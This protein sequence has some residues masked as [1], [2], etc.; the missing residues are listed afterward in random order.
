M[1]SGYLRHHGK[2]RRART[3]AR[4][5]QNSWR[6]RKWPPPDELH[7]FATEHQ[8]HPSHTAAAPSIQGNSI[9]ITSPHAVSCISH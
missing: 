6:T 5:H 2:A 4:F 1:S 3:E 9:G 7:N 8:E